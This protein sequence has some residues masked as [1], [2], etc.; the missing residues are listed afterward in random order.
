MGSLFIL[1]DKKKILWESILQQKWQSGLKLQGGDL[2]GM[3]KVSLVNCNFNLI[4]SSLPCTNKK[5]I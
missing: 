4:C 1:T 3:V 2:D 5:F